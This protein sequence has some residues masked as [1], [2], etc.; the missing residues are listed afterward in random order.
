M[1]WRYRQAEV[2]IESLQD[3]SAQNEAHINDLVRQL[4]AKNA[5]IDMREDDLQQLRE[6]LEEILSGRRSAAPGSA[7]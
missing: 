5:H 2:T 4:D 6:L 3:T 1:A 7:A